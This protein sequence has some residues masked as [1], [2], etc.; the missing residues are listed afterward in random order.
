MAQPNQQKNIFLRLFPLWGIALVLGVIWGIRQCN[1]P[2]Q[3]RTESFGVMNTV[4]ELDLRGPDP[5]LLE[6]GSAAVKSVF[7]RVEREANRFNPASE[8][9]ALNESAAESPFPCSLGLWNILTAAGNAY[10]E[11]NG[12]FDITLRPLMNIWGFHRKRGSIPDVPEIDSARSFTGF[13]KVVFNDSDRTVRFLLSGTS[14]DLGG[15]AKGYAVDLAVDSLHC[16]DIRG[17]VNLGGNLRCLGPETFRVGIRDPLKPDQNAGVV[18]V[19]G[20]SFST[21]G[22]YERFSEINGKRYSHIL[23]P[24]SGRPVDNGILSVTVKAPLAVQADAFSTAV[25]VRGAPLAETLCSR[26]SGLGILILCADSSRSRGWRV[27]AF[28]KGFEE[29]SQ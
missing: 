8:L 27:Q 12:A 7:R 11:T 16:L 6:E 5:R 26:H 23:D 9:F 25:F 4:A 21:S 18:T 24:A 29:V 1:P 17:I 14:F 3:S 28:G 19:C 10:G 15:I 22:S 20:E 13:D 2:Q